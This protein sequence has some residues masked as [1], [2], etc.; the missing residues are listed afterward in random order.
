MLVWE[1][2]ASVKHLSC[3]DC[4]VPFYSLG[5]N[6]YNDIVWILLNP[7]LVLEASYSYILGLWKCWRSS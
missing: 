5:P 4:I 1:I 2:L 3:I 7:Y 6:L